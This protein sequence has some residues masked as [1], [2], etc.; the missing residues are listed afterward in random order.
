MET[1]ARDAVGRRAQRAPAPV[2]FRTMPWTR[3]PSLENPKTNSLRSVSL[4]TVLPSGKIMETPSAVSYA[5]QSPAGDDLPA[6]GRSRRMAHRLRATE[7]HAAAAAG[8]I[9][10]GQ[11]RSV[12]VA[13]QDMMAFRKPGR[14]HSIASGPRADIARRPGGPRQD[15]GLIPAFKEELRTI[16]GKPARNSIRNLGNAEFLRRVDCRFASHGPAEIVDAEQKTG[17]QPAPP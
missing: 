5:I 17:N 12:G 14:I 7:N 15:P 1:E 4:R 11:A 2:V 9:D 8:D 10:N 16:R 6:A 13:R 3:A